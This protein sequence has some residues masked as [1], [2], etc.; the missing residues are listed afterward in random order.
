MQ[1]GQSRLRTFII[2]LLPNAVN[3]RGAQTY[4][5]PRNKKTDILQEAAEAAA[6]KNHI[7]YPMCRG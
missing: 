3:S 6:E 4:V 2:N 7:E 1:I 5:W